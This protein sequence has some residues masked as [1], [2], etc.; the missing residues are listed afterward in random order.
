MLG[1]EL[2]VEVAQVHASALN[3]WQARWEQTQIS[4]VE[5]GG[6]LEQRWF[7]R[8]HG[9][10]RLRLKDRDIEV[11]GGVWAELERLRTAAQIR[12]GPA[13]ARGL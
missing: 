7:L 9:A 3:A 8:P 11:E 5:G 13:L 10:L 6:T 2:G 1:Q 12:G 4:S